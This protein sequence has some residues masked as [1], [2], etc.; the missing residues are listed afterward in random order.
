MTCQTHAVEPP[1][2]TLVGAGQNQRKSNVNVYGVDP[3]TELSALK[4]NLGL[5]LPDCQH[6]VIDEFLCKVTGCA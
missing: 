1:E 3:R 5:G 2:T 6:A 4:R